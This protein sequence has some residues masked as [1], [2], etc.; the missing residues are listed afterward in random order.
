MAT[1]GRYETTHELYRTGP[2]VVYAGRSASGPA[3]QFVIKV[4]QPLAPFSDEKQLE[5]ES[6]LFISRALTQQKVADSGAQHWAPILQYGTTAKGAFYATDN[7]DRSLQ[8]LIDGHVKL[9]SEA[10]HTIIES[11]TKG[12]LELKQACS[13]PHGN[14][15]ATNV[16]IAG[17]RTISDSKIVLTDPSPDE[18]IDTKHWAGDLRAIAE[19]IYQLV[20]HCPTPAVT[21]WQ[22][23][24]S[25]NW[26]GLGRQAN[27]WKKLCNRLLNIHVEPAPMTIENLIEELAQLK[28]AKSSLKA[29]LLTTAAAFLILVI[30][31]LSVPSTR[32]HIHDLIWPPP[33]ETDWKLVCDEYISWVGDYRQELGEKVKNDEKREGI[34]SEDK[35]LRKIANWIKVASY[36]DKVAEKNFTTVEDLQGKLLEKLEVPPTQNKTR[37]ALNAIEYIKSF[38]DPNSD[39][40]WP[41]LSDINNVSNN[42]KN[43]GWQKSTIHLQDLIG[44]IKP[45]PNNKNSTQNVDKIL[46]LQPDLDDIESQWTK[47]EENQKIIES[48]GD[49][50]LAKFPNHV[51]SKLISADL[52]TLIRELKEVSSSADTLATFIKNDWQKV[53]QKTFLKDHGSDSQEILIDEDFYNR[54]DTIK[55]Y[56]Y[57]KPNPLNAL[58]K[59][60]KSIEDYMKMA[61]LSNPVEANR[62]AEILKK[63]QQD[64]KGVEKTPAIEKYKSNITDAVNNYKPKLTTLRD[65]VIAAAETPEKFLERVRKIDAIVVSEAINK[66]WLTLRG[67][68]LDRYP[69]SMLIENLTKYAELRQRIDDTIHNLG[70]LNEEFQTKLSSHLEVEM[71][72]KDW[73]SKIK[74]LYD[75]ERQEAITNIVAKI[76]LQDGIPDINDPSFKQFRQTQFFEFQQLRAGLSGILAAFNGVEDGLDACYLLDQNLTESNQTIRSLWTQW[77][78]TNIFKEPR[79]NDTLV[80]ITLRIGNLEKIEKFENKD[81]LVDIATDPKSQTE[82]VYAAWTRLGELSE[83]FWPDKPEEWQ[84]DKKIQERLKAEFETIKADNIERGGFLLETLADTSTKHEIIFREANIRRYKTEISTHN[85]TDKILS[86]FEAYVP[87]SPAPNL[88]E[89]KD[90]ENLTKVIMEFVTDPNWPDG[91]RTDLLKKTST[92]EK[93][94]LK[95]EDFLNWLKE[96]EDY[97]KLSDDPRNRYSWDV[98]IT[99]IETE[100]NNE[101]IRKQKQEQLKEL[102]SLKKDFDETKSQI[103]SLRSLPAIK[104][105]EEEIS[106]CRDYWEKLQTIKNKL[107]PDYCLR[108]DLVNERLVFDAA[109][110]DPSLFEPVNANKKTVTVPGWDEIRQAVDKGQKDWLDFFYTVNP[111]DSWNVGWPKY[112]RLTKDNSVIFRFIP[113][114]ISQNTRPFYMAICEITNEQYVRFLNQDRQTGAALSFGEIAGKNGAVLI[115]PSSSA[116]SYCSPIEHNGGD[117]QINETSKAKNDNPVVWITYQGAIAYTR[118]LSTELPTAAQHKY[119]CKYNTTRNAHIR[120]TAWRKEAED[121]NT[122]CGIKIPK[123]FPPVGAVK[124]DLMPVTEGEYWPRV[125]IQDFVADAPYETAWPSKTNDDGNIYGISDLIGNVWEWCNKDGSAVLCGGSC[126]S[127]PKYANQ[128]AEHSFNEEGS[129]CD[130]GFRVVLN[131]LQNKPQN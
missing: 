125:N 114:D 18:S 96:V 109:Y 58:T 65:R 92:Y 59:L 3:E 60:V 107:K 91:F 44:E 55:D 38:F 100:I 104:K 56:F 119:A 85:S 72:D 97:R 79:I 24:D 130:I 112:V 1:F 22:I 111:N 46:K 89:V 47:I 103:S 61:H 8:K 53:D 80:K 20:V 10:L 6:A 86:K 12:L 9:T 127:P 7:Y 76:P 81:T 45:G 115:M 27:D 35:D 11:I 64:M 15:K 98:E 30:I 120:S 63:L 87:Y 123:P 17:D 75:Q 28:K 131:L 57:L 73:N 29:S 93:V 32:R 13:R 67:N 94:T 34:W 129:S 48:T 54:I 31:I 121:Y 26:T 37:E 52:D 71:K 50:I 39:K 68:L 78:D 69:T 122:K 110:L 106:K 90:F 16:L 74:Q 113:S 21:G 4:L 116:H 95:K 77:K 51:Q 42:F 40:A 23:P 101:L 105:H 33:S 43:R 19:L 108:L 126:L 25:E 70:K 88:D 62:C 102:E 117:F 83:P 49:S 82:T 84:T 118:W 14:L 41:V 124:E 5:R 2:V 36:P 66:K 99:N 128:D